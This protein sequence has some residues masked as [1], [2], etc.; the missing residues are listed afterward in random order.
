[1]RLKE[2][3]TTYV[4]FNVNLGYVQGMNDI[5]AVFLLMM[6]DEADTFWCLKKWMDSNE[7]NFR[8][9]L[10]GVFQQLK[11]LSIVLEVLDSEL[12]AALSV[13]VDTSTMFW[14]FQWV[15]LCFKREF[16][17]PELH[18]IWEAVWTCPYSAN[19]HLFIAVAMIL[20]HR[21]RIVHDHV[22]FDGLVSMFNQ[23]QEIDVQWLLTEADHLCRRYL[24][25]L[26]RAEAVSGTDDER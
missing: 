3:L 18:M 4:I 8:G 15:L 24:R 11:E 20:R 19:L 14:C 26:P 1:V 13:H 9:D 25:T 2:V 5:A 16:E 6:E 22:Q 7:N 23:R 12:A 21:D 17:L 10:V